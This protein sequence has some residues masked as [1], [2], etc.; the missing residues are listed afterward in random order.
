MGSRDVKLSQRPTL[1]LSEAISSTAI[2][3]QNGDEGII[4]TSLGPSRRLASTLEA[5]LRTP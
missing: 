5:L 2:P 1:H 3:T 4:E